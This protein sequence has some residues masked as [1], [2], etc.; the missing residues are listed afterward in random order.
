[1]NT[2]PAPC[3]AMC[4]E[5]VEQGLIINLNRD[6]SYYTTEHEHQNL[7]HLGTIIWSEWHANCVIIS[8]MLVAILVSL[9]AS[10]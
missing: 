5:L 2:K 7:I 6:Y 1:M 3:A 4:L 9:S 8:A 10:T